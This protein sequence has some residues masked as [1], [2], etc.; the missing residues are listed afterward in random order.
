[1]FGQAWSDDV[2]VEGGHNGCDTR[3][4]VLRRDLRSVG[5]KPGSSGCTVLTGALQD[6]YTG[7]SIAFRRGQATSS[8]VQIDHI[9]ALGNPWETGAQQLSAERRRDLANDPLNLWAVSGAAN[10]Q[11]GAGDAATW[12]PANTSIRCVY[13]ARQVAVKL[14]YGLWVTGPERDAMKRVLRLPGSTVAHSQGL[15][16]TRPRGGLGARQHLSRLGGPRARM[17][18]ENH[19]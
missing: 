12:L 5:L 11:K 19:E 8:M 7:A 1:M 18:G 15:G 17:K 14:T 2:S 10:Q 6:P 4:D 13:V 16:H 3:N 9:V